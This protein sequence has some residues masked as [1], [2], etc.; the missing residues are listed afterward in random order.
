MQKRTICVSCQVEEDLSE[1]LKKAA[2]DA[3]VSVSRMVREALLRYFS[4]T[5]RHPE[6]DQLKLLQA[7]VAI[8]EG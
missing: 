6:V 5:A 3:R 1:R 4:E 8:L 2:A 7:E